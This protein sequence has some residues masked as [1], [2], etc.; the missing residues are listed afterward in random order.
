M[1]KA[2]AVRAA[3]EY[4]DMSI[5]FE[6]G[7]NTALLS[8]AEVDELI[9][10]LGTI[11]SSMRPG[12]P[13][14]PV[15]THQYVMEI[16]PSW[17]TELHPLF[18]GAA[19]FLRHSGLGWTSFALPLESLRKLSGALSAQISLLEDFSAHATVN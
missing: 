13:D 2:M 1:K 19:L 12:V 3:N 15:R 17:H 5:C 7:G 18:D 4:G 10:E 6:M 16:N 8:A 14:M 9:E 11:R